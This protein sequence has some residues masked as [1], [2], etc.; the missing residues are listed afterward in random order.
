MR[1]RNGG[2]SGWYGTAFSKF[3]AQ[4]S[5]CVSSGFI[6]FCF[7]FDHFMSFIYLVP[8]IPGNKGLY[9]KIS[10]KPS[11]RLWST[12]SGPL[13]SA[14]SETVHCRAVSLGGGD[15]SCGQQDRTNNAVIATRCCRCWERE[16]RIKTSELVRCFCHVMPRVFLRSYES[17][18]ASLYA[19]D[20]LS[21]FH[22]HK[23]GWYIYIYIYIYIYK[24]S[25]VGDQSRGWP[26]GSL[27]NSYYTEV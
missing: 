1:T 8:D 21:T 23:G 7:M 5:C 27:F 12:F 2:A 24:I 18:L 17:V 20:K 6:D 15:L 9:W 19:V 26:K 3:P 13:G 10:G 25:K 14:C 16:A 22:S 4:L 11:V